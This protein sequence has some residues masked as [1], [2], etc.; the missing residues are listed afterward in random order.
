MTKLHLVIRP[1]RLLLV[2]LFAA[3]MM[4]QAV[5]LPGTI[6]HDAREATGRAHL[7]WPLLTVSILGL[8]CAQVVIVCT[9][10]LLTMVEDDRIFT[11]E[12]L[13][14]VDAIVWAIFSAWVLLAGLFLYVIPQA[15]DPGAPVLMM[16]LLLS[17]AG[18]GFLMVVMRALLRRATVLRT[19]LETLI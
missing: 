10:R 7:R 14:W 18:F 12:S 9:W 2:A 11:E 19:T 16:M 5:I 6:W 8:L 1:L 4:F 15:D 13:A 17:G 3:L